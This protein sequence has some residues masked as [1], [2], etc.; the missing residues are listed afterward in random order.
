MPS[1]TLGGTRATLLG[2]AGA[3]HYCDTHPEKVQSHAAM[4]VMSSKPVKALV[5]TKTRLNEGRCCKS[6]TGACVKTRVLVSHAL[7]WLLTCQKHSC[8]RVI[9]VRLLLLHSHHGVVVSS[10]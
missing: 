1:D 4:R 6:L 10:T 7:R 8:A 2:T 5:W 9:V 3:S